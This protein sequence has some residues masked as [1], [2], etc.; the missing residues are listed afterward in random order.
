M[1]HS[2]RLRFESG[3]VGRRRYLQRFDMV[4]GNPSLRELRDSKQ[5]AKRTWLEAILIHIE[6]VLGAAKVSS[7]AM[8]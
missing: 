2:G 8:E 7:V 1:Y 5:A 3:S 6:F 4:R